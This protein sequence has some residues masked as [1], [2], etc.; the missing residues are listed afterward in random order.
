VDAVAIG[1]AP[2]LL[3]LFQQLKDRVEM[4]K[5]RKEAYQGIDNE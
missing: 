5:A 2:V 1:G 3:T 4:A